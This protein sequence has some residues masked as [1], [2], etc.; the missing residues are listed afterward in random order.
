MIDDAIWIIHLFSSAFKMKTK[1]IRIA[2]KYMK[3]KLK[4]KINL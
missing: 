3:Y 4:K 2:Y 1:N